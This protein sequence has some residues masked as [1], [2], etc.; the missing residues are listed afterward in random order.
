MKKIDPVLRVLLREERTRTREASTAQV[1]REALVA[2][3]APRRVSVLVRFTGDVEDLRAAGFEP[4][5]VKQ[6]PVK[7]FKLA[8]GTAPL[9]R[10]EEIAAIKHVQEMEG[11][12]TFLPQMDKSVPEIKAREGHRASTPYTGKGVV[13]GIIDSGIDFL[14]ADFRKPDKTTRILALW[15]Q[16]LPDSD[17]P[18]RY[19]KGVE[20]TQEQINAA[21]QAAEASCRPKINPFHLVASKDDDPERK[22]HGTHVAGIAAGNGRGSEGRRY[23]GAAP[24]ST[25]LF[26]KPSAAAAASTSKTSTSGA[27]CHM[28]GYQV[29]F[30]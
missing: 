28:N 3:T 2:V 8:S 17:P 27:P 30:W 19:S 26:Q 7:P 25:A 1:A 24:E 6:H 5:I 10:I 18:W 16:T 21:L 29:K 20:Y 22:G 13:I 12:R 9:D 11:P 23:R 4:R 15:D 14:H